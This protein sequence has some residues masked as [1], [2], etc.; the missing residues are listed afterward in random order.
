VKRLI[1]AAALGFGV[2]TSAS[3]ATLVSG[4]S[5]QNVI[6]GL[7]TAAGTS[8]AFAPN[9][10]TN[11][12]SPDQLWKINATGGSVATVIIELAGNAASNKFGIYDPLTGKSVQVFDGSAGS[13]SQALLSIMLDGSVRLNF[14]D[15]GVDFSGNTFGYYLE[16][17]SGRLYSENERNGN[18]DMMVT[19]RGDGDMIQ[20]A[21]YAAGPWGSD[22]YILAWED[23]AN[24]D[25]DFDDF[26]L[27]VE[28]VT[29]VPEPGMLALLGATLA[30]LGFS[31]R[32]RRS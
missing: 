15:T 9:V 7:Y 11:Q 19:Y 4:S 5:L 21:G 16:G 10:N 13:G 22:E 12:H 28:S 31:A 14:A 3:A 17:A 8:T 20:I 18:S 32:R 26:V 1:A 27:M 30:G 29:S 6:N 23:T 2:M 25:R 24:G